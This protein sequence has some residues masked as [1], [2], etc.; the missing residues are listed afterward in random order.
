MAL[1]GNTI[2]EALPV[3]VNLASWS[4]NPPITH[5]LIIDNIEPEG[6]YNEDAD[7][8]EE[9]EIGRHNYKFSALIGHNG[10]GN[11]NIGKLPQAMS[12]SSTWLVVKCMIFWPPSMTFYDEGHILNKKKSVMMSI[13]YQITDLLE[14][15]SQTVQVVKN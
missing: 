2:E 9:D 4:P 15:F 10:K 1:S 6:G 7:E 5:S 8:V 3:S 13:K 11:S 12:L 14:F